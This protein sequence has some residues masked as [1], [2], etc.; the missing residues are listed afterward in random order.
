MLHLHRWVKFSLL[1]ATSDWQPAILLSLISFWSF[2]SC[3]RDVNGIEWTFDRTEKITVLFFPPFL[4]FGPIHF[5]KVLLWLYEFSRRLLILETLSCSWVER[6]VN[7]RWCWYIYR[8]CSVFDVQFDMEIGF[9]MTLVLVWHDIGIGMTL[10]S[11][12]H[13]STITL[14][15]PFL[16]TVSTELRWARGLLLSSKAGAV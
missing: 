3:H 11:A 7:S 1:A 4:F 16:L 13:L 6:E 14:C 12:Y 15:Q 5:C 8:I 9:S 10:V 2:L